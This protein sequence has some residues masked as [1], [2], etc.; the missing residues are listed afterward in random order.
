MKQV[1][2]YTGLLV[3]FLFLAG[4]ASFKTVPFGGP[5]KQ[6]VRTVGLVTVNTP[7]GLTVSVRA[8]TAANFGLIG[9]IIEAS[10]I[11]KKSKAFTDAAESMNFSVQKQLTTQLKADLEAEGYKVNSVAVERKGDSFLENYPAP[12]GNDAFLDVVVHKQEA[13]YRAAGDS[14]N[15]YPYLFVTARLVSASSNKLLYAD[16]IVYNPI[17]PPPNARTI[18]PDSKYGYPDFDHLMAKPKQSVEGL[19]EAV[20]RVA[21]AIAADLK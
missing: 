12:G 18:A 8:P 2:T 15:Y 17:N 4:C 1:A 6:Q 9:G 16:Q 20:D 14:T 13:G 19:K 3:T 21:Q 11:D 10:E 7:P 5:A